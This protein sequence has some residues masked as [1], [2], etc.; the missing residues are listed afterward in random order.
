LIYPGLGVIDRDAYLMTE[1]KRRQR[2]RMWEATRTVFLTTQR[3]LIVDEA[4]G[5]QTSLSLRD[6]YD[7]NLVPPPES[8]PELS[9]E[10]TI[11]VAFGADKK[12]RLVHWDAR[13]ADAELFARML[14][15]AVAKNEGL[16]TTSA[17]LA[18][19]A[20]LPII[21]VERVRQGIVEL[22]PEGMAF[23]RTLIPWDEMADVRRGEGE[24]SLL[25]VG[26]VLS[27]EVPDLGSAIDPWV[28][29]I[30]AHGVSVTVFSRKPTE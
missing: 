27:V 20:T 8:R 13:A 1:R 7:V 26:Y 2:R 24:D 12:R 3:L 19:G 23:A 28:S 6:I 16:Q 21:S 18:P 17:L 29:Y 5:H 11:K 10:M 25:F 30:E 9:G 22:K 14:Q 4:M 15:E